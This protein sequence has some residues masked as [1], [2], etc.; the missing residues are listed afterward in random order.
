MMIK[1]VLVEKMEEDVQG[2]GGGGFLGEV[3]VQQ[4]LY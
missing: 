4:C 1:V 2:T 3:A